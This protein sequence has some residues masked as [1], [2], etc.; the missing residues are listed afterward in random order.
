MKALSNDMSNI[1]WT[2]NHWPERLL[3]HILISSVWM[4][5]WN[6]LTSPTQI[7][8]EKGD[9]GT[10]YITY[11]IR[12]EMAWV[13]KVGPKCRIPTKHPSGIIWQAFEDV[14]VAI[15]EHQKRNPVYPISFNFHQ[16]GRILHQKQVK[17]RWI[18]TAISTETGG[19][20][21]LCC[22]FS[23]PFDGKPTLKLHF[24]LHPDIRYCNL[25]LKVL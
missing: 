24:Y 2:T 9:L 8:L 20:P 21:H 13:S 1:S 16:T 7:L 19:W 11:C 12:P 15:C 6:D 18:I 22:E 17:K 5:E 14:R 3:P 10:L 4:S 23:H 25:D